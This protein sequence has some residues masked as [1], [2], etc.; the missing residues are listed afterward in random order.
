MQWPYLHNCNTRR[1]DV[2][3]E[4]HMVPRVGPPNVVILSL[5]IFEQPSTEKPSLL[6]NFRSKTPK[7]VGCIGPITKVGLL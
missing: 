7:T 1:L 2:K 6:I 3:G 5:R 4:T